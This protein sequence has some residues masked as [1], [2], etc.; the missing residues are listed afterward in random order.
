MGIWFNPSPAAQPSLSFSVCQRDIYQLMQ[1]TCFPSQGGQFDVAAT[2]L[3]T[4]PGVGTNGSQ[5]DS[6]YPSY[7]IVPETYHNIYTD[8]S[9]GEDASDG[10]G[11]YNGEG[12]YDGN[13]EEDE[14]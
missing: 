2:N 4:L 6:G 12:E 8:T 3:Q 7:I 5:V 1:S 11:E 14:D 13:G 10:E 9:D